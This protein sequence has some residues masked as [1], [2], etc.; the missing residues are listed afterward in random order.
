MAG[1]GS[2]AVRALPFL[3]FSLPKRINTVVF[4]E[5][6]IFQHARPVPFPVSFVKGSQRV[7]GEIRTFGAEL[8]APFPEQPAPLFQKSTGFVPRPA[9]PAVRYPHPP[10]FYIMGTGKIV[11]A[12]PA[13]HPA[14]CDQVSIVVHGN[15]GSPG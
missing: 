8:H 5:C 1:N 7:A 3:V 14:G 2:A 12:N 13:V 11:A 9:P 4:D 6:E 10:R 15:S